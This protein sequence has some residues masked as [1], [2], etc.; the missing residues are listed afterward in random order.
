MTENN[1][2]MHGKSNIVRLSGILE[3]EFVYSHYTFEQGFFRNRIVVKR[4]SGAE[5]HIPIVRSERFAMPAF[6]KG[7]AI[8]L[9]GTFRSKNVFDQNGRKHVSRFVFPRDVQVYESSEELSNLNENFIY[10]EGNICMPPVFRKTPLGRTI[11]EVILA[12]RRGGYDK[13]DYIPCIA[14]G[15]NAYLVKALDVGSHL[16]LEGRIQSRLYEKEGDVRETY[17]VSIFKIE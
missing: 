3:E 14:W 12:V 15:N 5:D 17:E 4:L 7:K 6:A 1:K 13:W 8:E 11:T 9:V 16:K 10:L 2:N